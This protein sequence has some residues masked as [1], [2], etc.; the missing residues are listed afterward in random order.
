[1]SFNATTPKRL[2]GSLVDLPAYEQAAILTMA[3]AYHIP[4]EALGAIRVH[5]NGR[6]GGP[7]TASLAFGIK[8]LAAEEQ[9]EYGEQLKLCAESIANNLVRFQR[10]TGQSAWTGTRIIDSFWPFMALRYCPVGAADDPTGLNKHWAK[11]V[12]DIYR[13]AGWDWVHA[14]PPAPEVPSEPPKVSP[15][16]QK[17]SVETGSPPPKPRKPNR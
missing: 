15:P 2:T 11:G 1:M 7:S 14:S 3:E 9:D 13:G 8:S 5:E 10:A 17:G 6:G 12:C 4:P 16:P